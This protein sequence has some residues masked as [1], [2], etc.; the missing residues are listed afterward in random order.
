L[1][2]QFQGSKVITICGSASG[3]GKSTLVERLGELISNSVTLYFDS[4][5]ETTV[6]PPN[7]YEDLAAG[8][9][10]DV[11]EIES[12][13]FYKDL[14]LLSQGKAI[15]DPWNRKLKPADY[16][17]LEEPF[18]RLRTGMNDIIDFVACIEL[19]QDIALARR[20]LRNLRYDFNHLTIEGR[21]EYIESFLEEYLRGGRISYIKLFEAVSSDCDLFLNG[22]LSTD[23]MAHEVIKK[24]T[25]MKILIV[26]Q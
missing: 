13:L 11:R 20:L 1:S 14:Q 5:H 7:V 21:F 26:N 25:E 23:E 9:E 10:V 2:Q 8:K 19:P 6:Y 17:I 18:G 3:V 16:I 24:L 15:K 4:Y 22:L 12:P